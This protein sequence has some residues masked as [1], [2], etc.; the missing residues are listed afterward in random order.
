M[1]HGRC[2]RTGWLIRLETITFI[3]NC[4]GSSL[5]EL[6]PSGWKIL[7]NKTGDLNQD[8]FQ[9]LAFVIQ[10]T[11]PDA[12]SL[13]DGFGG[14]T[15][16]LN[17]RL[18]EIY[19]GSESGV[20]KRVLQSDQFIIRKDSPTMDEPF[21]GLEI[22]EKGI[23]EVQF[24]IWHS[25]GSWFTSNH[26]YKF[27]YQDNQFALIGYDWVEAHRASGDTKDYSINFLAKKMEITLGNYT[28]DGPGS[29]ESIDFELDQLKTLES[30]GKPFEWEF[31]GIIL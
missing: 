13:N 18:L 27:R 24:H 16:D 22:T 7:D 9:D 4:E 6:I 28:E 3:P 11:D 14:D 20:L 2:K 26:T 25:A 30:M 12:F 15:L 5:E 29:V 10:D 8:G 21:A 1:I 19:F 23:L 31:E 17:P